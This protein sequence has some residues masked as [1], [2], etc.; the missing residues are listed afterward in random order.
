VEEAARFLRVSRSKLYQIMD[1]GEVEY[2]KLGRRRRVPD[3]MLLELV[4]RSTVRAGK[5]V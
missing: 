2:I 4:K 1:K 3:R 5:A